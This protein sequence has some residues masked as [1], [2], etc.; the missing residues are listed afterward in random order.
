MTTTHP[1]DF[2]LVAADVRPFRG[3]D[4]QSALSVGTFSGAR[5]RM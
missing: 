1:P 5:V 2:V 4:E 3:L